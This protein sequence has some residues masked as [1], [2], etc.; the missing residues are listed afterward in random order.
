MEAGDDWPDDLLQAKMPFLPKDG[1]PRMSLLLQI[2]V[3]PANHLPALGRPAPT[4]A[5]NLGGGAGPP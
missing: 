5:A 2:A 3:H 1:P 4:P